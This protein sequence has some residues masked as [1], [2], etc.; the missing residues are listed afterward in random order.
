MKAMDVEGS[1]SN[2]NNPNSNTNGNALSNAE[3]A[4]A[5]EGYQRWVFTSTF[6]N[7]A[8]AHWTRKSYTNVKLQLMLAGVSPLTVTAMDSGFMFTYAG[9]SFVT[10]LLGDRFSPVVVVGGGK[11]VLY[12]CFLNITIV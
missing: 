2:S 8:M 10:G 7:Y 12:N 11:D 3:D 4:A 9:G 6:M 1:H 5:L